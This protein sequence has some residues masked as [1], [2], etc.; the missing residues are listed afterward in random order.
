MY[1]AGF[2]LRR[3]RRVE[4]AAA[5]VI[6]VL[7]V[8]EEQEEFDGMRAPTGDVAGE[9]LHDEDGALATAERDGVGDFGARVVDGRGDAVHRLVADEVADV[10]DD[11]RGAGFDELIVVK[12]VEV[13]GEDGELFVND[14]QERFERAAGGFRQQS[15]AAFLLDRIGG[16]R[17]GF[18]FGDFGRRKEIERVGELA[19][20]IL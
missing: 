2:H 6:H 11:P 1:S 17:D 9:L 16:R 19:S 8:G 3:S 10:G 5:D 18:E 7:R 13:F 15:V 4:I 20:R 14:H 12:L